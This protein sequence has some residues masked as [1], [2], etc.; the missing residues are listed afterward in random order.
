M[1]PIL[2]ADGEVTDKKIFQRNP[3]RRPTLPS[4]VN[5]SVNANIFSAGRDTVLNI[6]GP[7]LIQKDPVEGNS[8][9]YL[10]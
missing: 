4:N 3:V 8:V 6:G 10:L 9:S 5:A 1:E 7:S 2:G